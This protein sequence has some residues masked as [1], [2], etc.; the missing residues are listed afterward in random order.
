MVES[1][2]PRDDDYEHTLLLQLIKG[3]CNDDGHSRRS[4]R[5]KGKRKQACV[6]R[7]LCCHAIMVSMNGQE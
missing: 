2:E 6:S 4:E 7:F 5:E 1:N 3:D